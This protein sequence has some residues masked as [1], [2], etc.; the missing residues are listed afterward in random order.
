MAQV[1]VDVVC[2]GAGPFYDERHGMYHLM[3][4]DHLA[5]PQPSQGAALTG[6]S[7]GHWVSRYDHSCV[8]AENHRLT[9]RCSAEIFCAGLS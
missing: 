5:L 4:Q 9:I 3:Y 8:G 7:W 6:P 1:W 2:G